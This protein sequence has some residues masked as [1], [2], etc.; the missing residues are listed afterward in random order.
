MSQKPTCTKMMQDSVLETPASP[1]LGMQN[2]MESFEL[3]R[4]SHMVALASD[5]SESLPGNGSGVLMPPPLRFSARRGVVHD[6]HD[7]CVDNSTTVQVKLRIIR[8]IGE[9]IDREESAQWT[10][11]DDERT[12]PAYAIASLISGLKA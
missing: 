2:L 11:G 3:E 10:C 4:C 12:S 6:R 5:E 8:K 9:E 7:R 1:A